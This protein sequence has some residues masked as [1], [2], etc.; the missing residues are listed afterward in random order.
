MPLVTTVQEA[1]SPLADNLLDIGSPIN[2]GD[3]VATAPRTG[4]VPAATLHQ[5]IDAL[6]ISSG[7]VAEVA[8][9]DATR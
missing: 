5:F 4:E 9:P 7:S 3:A 6:T 8:N 1:L 2:A